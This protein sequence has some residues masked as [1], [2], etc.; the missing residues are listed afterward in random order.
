MQSRIGKTFLAFSAVAMML[1]VFGQSA[2]AQHEYR[3]DSPLEGVWQ[4]TVTLVVCGTQ[5]PVPGTSPFPS[6]GTFVRGGTVVEDTTNPSFQPGQ[7]SPGHGV[8]ERVSHD[9]FKERSVAFINFAAPGPPP[10]EAGKQFL[11]QTIT[12]D[13]RSDTWSAV[14]A[15]AFTD[16]NGNVYRTGCATATATRF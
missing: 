10:L 2:M 1:S 11:N 9:V 3:A 7:R 8:W 15:I 6:L 5:N 14:A 16:V 4:V 13:G 12:Y